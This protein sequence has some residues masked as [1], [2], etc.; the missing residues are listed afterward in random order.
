MDVEVIKIYDDKG[1]TVLKKRI[2]EHLNVGKGDLLV[3][4]LREDNTVV[5]RALRKER[6][7][8]RLR[9]VEG[10]DKVLGGRAVLRFEMV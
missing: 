2:L 8:V 5:L 4:E 7:L 3:A 10:E 9:H 1:H 6:F